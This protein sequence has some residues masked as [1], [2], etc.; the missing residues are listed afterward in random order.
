MF[1]GE[2]MDLILLDTMISVGLVE[3][4]LFMCL[5]S[6]CTCTNDYFYIQKL[7]IIPVLQKSKK[8]NMRTSHVIP[9][10]K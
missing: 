9:F 10:P 2:N 4:I 6:Q 1:S 5:D 3:N 7:K 8:Y